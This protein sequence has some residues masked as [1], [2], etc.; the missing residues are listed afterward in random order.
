MH[1]VKQ[2]EVVQA[3][4]MSAYCK[5]QK[6][7]PITASTFEDPLQAISPD[8][9]P[10]HLTAPAYFVSKLNPQCKQVGACF[11]KGFWWQKQI[12][13]HQS[14]T[15]EGQDLPRTYLAHHELESVTIIVIII[16]ASLVHACPENMSCFC[17]QAKL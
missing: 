2:I 4:C 13:G 1:E 14:L 8:P 11:L 12:H 15:L 5:T 17:R 9:C 10:A 16:K 7:L 6:L 3:V